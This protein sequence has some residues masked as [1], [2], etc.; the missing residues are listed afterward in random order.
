LFLNQDFISKDLSIFFTASRFIWIKLLQIREVLS[1]PSFNIN[2]SSGGPPG[3]NKILCSGSV[4]S[5]VKKT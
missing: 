3:L 4:I 5:V 1:T 2:S